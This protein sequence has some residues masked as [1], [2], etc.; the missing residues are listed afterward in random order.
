M[1][2]KLHT[3]VPG[4][5]KTYLLVKSF[6]DLFCTWDKETGRFILKDD[7][8]DKILVSN[9]DGLTIPHLDIET[10]MNERC[11][12]LAKAQFIDNVGKHKIEAMEDVIDKYY[13]EFL[14][15]KVRWFFNYTHQ[16]QLADKHG[17][18]IYLIE[19]SQRYFDSKE[20][21][22]KPWVRD[23]HYFF[24][25]HRHFGFSI[26]MDT[27]HASKLAKGIA[28]LFETEIQAKPR[29]LSLMGEFKY[30]E[31]SDGAKTN[32][33]PIVV[34]PDKR[35]FQVYKSMS[36]KEDVKTK[37]PALKILAFVILMAMLSIF[38]LNYAKNNLGPGTVHAQS[39]KTTPAKST[40]PADPTREIPGAWVHLSYFMTSTG[41]ITVV[42]PA[43]QSL[44]PLQSLEMK[45]ERQGTEL[46]CFM[47][48]TP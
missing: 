23:V 15:E 37:K 43:T 8:K 44:V 25:K 29:T 48:D 33:I 14:D 18:L 31:Y 42:H 19:E 38:I 16:K 9:I 46:Y 26:F 4:S 32:Q 7:H 10:L 36:H 17:P 1:V 41:D 3:G 22:R 47:E 34:K 5:G 35:V 30:N 27:Q 2:M 11:M 13:Y 24:E 39:P 20:L 21:G 45:V 12:Q 28:V 6:I 40:T